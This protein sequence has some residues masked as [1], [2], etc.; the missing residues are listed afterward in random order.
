MEN[1]VFYEQRDICRG[2]SRLLEFLA[3]NCERLWFYPWI[4]VVAD[5]CVPELKHSQGTFCST[6]WPTW[7]DYWPPRCIE[8]S[9]FLASPHIGVSCCYFISPSRFCSHLNGLDYSVEFSVTLECLKGFGIFV[10]KKIWMGGLFTKIL[11][12]FC[13]SDLE[14]SYSKVFKNPCLTFLKMQVGVGVCIYTCL[15]MHIR[16]II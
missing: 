16:Q 15:Y 13:I 14:S 3:F 9:E 7:R 4:K 2:G 5:C 10:K 11:N 8:E 1:R 12:I 6:G